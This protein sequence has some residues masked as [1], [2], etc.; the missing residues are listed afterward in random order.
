MSIVCHNS[1]TNITTNDLVHREL[2]PESV[3][4]Y[5][6]YSRGVGSVVQRPILG[7]RS[8]QQQIL[9]PSSRALESALSEPCFSLGE[10]RL[11]ALR[12]HTS[13]WSQSS[14]GLCTVERSLGQLGLGGRELKGGATVHAA[15]DRSGTWGG[16]ERSLGAEGSQLVTRRSRSAGGQ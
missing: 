2:S 13:E 12:P 5:L 15:W 1:A 7:S 4:T 14:G 11:L 16:L 6:E 8:P 10:G 3:A 9:R